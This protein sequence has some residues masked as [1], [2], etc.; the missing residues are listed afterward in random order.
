LPSRKPT[1]ETP[2]D[3]SPEKAYPLL[4]TQLAKLQELK[5]RSHSEVSNL[6]DEW[7]GLT[8]KLIM[9]TFGRS[10]PNFSNFSAGSSAGSY[11]MQP[12]GG[13]PDHL[14]EQRNFQSR[15]DAYESALRSSI[16]ELEIDLPDAVKGVYEPGEEY[17]F[18]RDVKACLKLAQREIF[19]IDPYLNVEIFDVYAGG[20]PRTVLFRLLSANVPADVVTLAQKYAT[21]GNLAFR[22]SQS[23][24]DRLF[25]ADARVWL[26]GQSFKDAAKKK[27]T[28][29]VEHDEPLMR[30]VYE[31]MWQVATII[32]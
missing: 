4:K 22:S 9:R 28:Y 31:S 13:R 5:G 12:F 27:P 3:L 8:S 23:I 18:Y 10:S 20:I 30:S 16:A 17:E 32:I 1:P 11:V 19:V 2:P 7:F 21:G 14:R 6:E 15:T 29:I 25:F 24:H 26:S